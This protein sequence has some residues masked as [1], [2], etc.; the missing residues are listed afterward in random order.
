MT[1][2]V[3][4]YVPKSS[5]APH[6][7]AGEGK[8]V[9]RAGSDFVPAPHGV[10][11]GLFGRPPH[12]V[13]YP[14][15]VIG[16]AKVTGGSLMLETKI[17]WPSTSSVGVDRSIISPREFRLAPG[18]FVSVVAFHLRIEANVNND[19]RCRLIA[20]C[21]GAIPHSQEMFVSKKEL[22]DLAAAVTGGKID[23]QEAAEKIL[24]VAE[25]QSQV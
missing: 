13:I 20:G 3:A 19:L 21:K 12:P 9:I 15:F 7:L 22:Q 25:N 4:T 18:G 6:Q 5:H 14:N 24:G 8:Y 17:D 16:P 23:L 10:V 2:I 11:A 1:G